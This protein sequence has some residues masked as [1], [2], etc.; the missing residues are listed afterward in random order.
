MSITSLSRIRHSL[1]SF[2]FRLSLFFVALVIV[3]MIAVALVLFRLI[4]DSEN[5]KADARVSAARSIAA[6]VYIDGV[7]SADAAL[8]HVGR[9]RRL[10]SALARGNLTVVRHRARVLASDHRIRRL[11]LLRG[12]H[13]LVDFGSGQAIAPAARDLIGPGGHRLGQLQVALETAAT[14]GARVKQLAGVEVAVLRNGKLIGTTA[15]GLQN[16]QLPN[17]GNVSAANRHFRVAS[18]DATGFR[19]VPLRITVLSDRQPTSSAVADSRLIAGGILV[20]FFIVAFTCA[21]VVS[22]SLQ[23]QIAGFLAAARRLGG[24]D[25]SAQVP[26]SGRDEFAALGEEFN[27]MSAQLEARLAELGDQR[28]RLESALQRIGEAFAS[29]LDRDGLLEVVLRA[30]VDGVGAEGGRASARVSPGGPL[31]ER[32]RVGQVSAFSELLAQVENGVLRSHRP[33]DAAGDSG[34]ALGHP[35]LDDHVGGSDGAGPVGGLISVAR[36]DRPF[37]APE[38]ELFGYLAAQ[39]AVSIENVSLHET[40]QL[41]AVTDELTGLYNHRRFQEALA[42]ELERS[43][44]FEQDMSLVMLDIDNF[45]SINDTYGH[46]QGDLVL[47]E[48]AR[49]LRENSREIDAPARY[50]GEELA[51]V[52]P[53]TDQ[54]GA[55]NLAERVRAG[56][57]D[58]KLPVL[59]GNG[60]MS[61]TASLGVA[62]LARSA[63]DAGELVAAADA[64]LYEAKRGGKN[65]TVRAH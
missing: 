54:N 64:A 14:Y 23:G 20:I 43:K 65:K 34:W 62:S 31:E 30:A 35:L 39:A 5:G 55:F 25:F 29:N 6:N 45:K 53:Q 36:S 11:V 38:V 50:G 57:E 4:S 44:R 52:L 12:T 10:A 17:V 16:R 8:T 28:A 24:G 18:F 27:K 9:D 33:R 41:Q 22:R 15:R 48:V 46:Q 56:I 21:V 47:R 2:R 1:A 7:H 58:L 13:V 63:T 19:G 42:S 3:P 49:I 40:V 51:V 26:V 60:T 61:V 37:T 32:A 59:E